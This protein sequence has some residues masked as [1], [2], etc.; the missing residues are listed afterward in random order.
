[1]LRAVADSVWMRKT[2]GRVVA[3]LGGRH[4]YQWTSVN[5]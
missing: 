4:V 2:E 5:E 1:M 3:L